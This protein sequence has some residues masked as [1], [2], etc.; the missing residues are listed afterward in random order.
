VWPFWNSITL[1]IFQN[2]LCI[3]W[4]LMCKL[5]M[6]LWIPLCPMLCT[7]ELIWPNLNYLCVTTT[8]C[9]L[10]HLCHSK[11]ILR[12]VEVF[13]LFFICRGHVNSLNFCFITKFQLYF[14]KLLKTCQNSYTVTTSCCTEEVTL[15]YMARLGPGSCADGR[16]VTPLCMAWLTLAFLSYADMWHD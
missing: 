11:H 12:D 8:W 16:C 5:S 7:T 9:C 14:K 10:A 15:L 6:A 4:I 1:K 2:G 13:F 3:S